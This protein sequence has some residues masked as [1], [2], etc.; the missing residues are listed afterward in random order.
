[1]GLAARDRPERLGEKLYKIRLGLG[2]TQVQMRDHLDLD[3]H[4]A[5]LSL[6]E[7]DKAEP[8]LRALLKYARSVGIWVDVLIDD[9]LDLPPIK[10]VSPRPKRS[11]RTMPARR[12]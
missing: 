3:C 8:P 12:R 9:A 2:L 4:V 1:M 10:P 11:K 5:Y 6:W 7:R